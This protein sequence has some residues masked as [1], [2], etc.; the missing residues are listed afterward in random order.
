MNK[1]ENL[2]KKE[3]K[4]ETLVDKAIE[5]PIFR[6]KLIKNL[7]VK[8]DYIRFNSH[9][10]LL[11]LSERT[12]EILY[13]NWD[14]FANLLKSSNN[15]QIV[16]GI[17]LLANLARVDNQ[18]KFEGLFDEYCGLLDAKSVMTASHLA[19][20][21]GKIAKAKPNLREKVTKRLLNIDKTHHEPQR[22][23]LIKASVI[24]SFNEYFDMVE[25]KTEI[26]NFVKS[27]LKSQSQKA[28]KMAE[29]FLKKKGD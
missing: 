2:N 10:V 13:P 23:D 24:E 17:Q 12:P 25:N 18:A 21:L 22:K 6:E 4:P 15:F 14:F 5:D 19:L 3:F 16:I 29:T 7:L 11:I 8:D 1:M 9:K 27:Q 26:I 28:R 20:N